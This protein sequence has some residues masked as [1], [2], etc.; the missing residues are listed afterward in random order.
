MTSNAGARRNQSAVAQP[1]TPTVQDDPQLLAFIEESSRAP[2]VAPGDLKKEFSRIAR[3]LASSLKRLERELA[4]AEMSDR[5]HRAL[6]E[7]IYSDVRR[8]MN[9]CG[10][11]AERLMEFQQICEREEMLG[12]PWN[13]FKGPA[14]EGVEIFTGAKAILRVHAFYKDKGTDTAPHTHR[15][16]FF[17]MHLGGKYKHK[18]HQ[19][20]RF[21]DARRNVPA[22]ATPRAT[23]TT[24]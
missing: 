1:A 2:R 11:D 20:E 22:S 18:V 10:K 3:S 23:A 17:S 14:F 4:T 15:K 21:P 6:A 9:L 5:A 8:A 24:C 7:N 16:H 13:F 12:Q 19:L